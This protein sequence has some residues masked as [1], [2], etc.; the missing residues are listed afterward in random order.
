MRKGD[1]LKR[2]KRSGKLSLRWVKPIIILLLSLSISP[3]CLQAQD[4]WIKEYDPF[5]NNA[6]QIYHPEDLVIVENGYVLNCRYEY[7]INPP[8]MEIVKKGFIMKVD[9][10]GNEQ[11]LNSFGLYSISTALLKTSDGGFLESHFYDM[12][13]YP[14]SLT[15]ID[16]N[17]NIVWTKS[18]DSFRPYSMDSTSDGNIIIGGSD[19]LKGKHSIRKVTQS[20]EIIW[21]KTYDN[22]GILYAIIQSSDGGY[23]ATGIT[24]GNSGFPDIFIIRI[25]ENGNELWTRSADYNDL[26]DR[27]S[28]LTETKDGS[29][30]IGGSIDSK[31]GR[32]ALLIKVDGLGKT[33]NQK[34]IEGQDI[35]GYRTIFTL[36]DGTIIGGY[37]Q[38]N[39]FDENLNEIW[40]VDYMLKAS[41]KGIK[42]TNDEGLIFHTS[43]DSVFQIIKTNS[44]GKYI[45]KEST[46]DDNSFAFTDTSGTQSSTSIKETSKK[47]RD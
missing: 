7:D 13:P 41:E 47:C 1:F 30:I 10:S 27:G 35:F 34:I 15:K 19:W 17:G 20:G 32:S 23:I 16:I 45:F 5:E 6:W 29:F 46:S 40:T 22:F 11:W 38:V 31:D 3:L 12:Y 25:D 33:L 24:D 2:T 26:K 44:M 36:D 28:T 39:K 14:S 4:T 43:K 8:H 18:Y 9:K 42:Q 37:P 21:S